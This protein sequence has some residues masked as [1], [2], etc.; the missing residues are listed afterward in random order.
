MDHR[1]RHDDRAY[2]AL[3]QIVLQNLFQN[4]WKSTGKTDRPV[5]RVGALGRDKHKVYF[6]A[7]NGAGF[8]MAYTG[9]LFGAFERL[10]H[11]S[12]FEGTGIGL[13]IVQRIIRRHEGRILAEA[14]EGE[15]ATFFFS[16]GVVAW[17]R[18]GLWSLDRKRARLPG[19]ST[20][21]RKHALLNT[22]PG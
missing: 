20:F 9:R 5:I 15:G 4:A 1:G 12:D 13:A 21:R 6:I 17:W 22:T 3:I 10:H 18:T 19:F 2:N 16:E 8:D 7:D 11:E 14:K